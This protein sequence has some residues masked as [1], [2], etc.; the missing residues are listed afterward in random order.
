[1]KT[2]NVVFL[3]ECTDMASYFYSVKADNENQAI[4]KARPHFIKELSNKLC[5]LTSDEVEIESEDYYPKV[6]EIKTID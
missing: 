4:E 3:A 2:F 1:M 5:R 6:F